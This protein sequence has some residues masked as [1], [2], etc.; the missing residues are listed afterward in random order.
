VS[1]FFNISYNRKQT[2]MM[3]FRIHL[4][5][6]VC[7]IGSIAACTGS[8]TPSSGQVTGTPAEAFDFAEAQKK[9]DPAARYSGDTLDS[10][11]TDVVTFIGRKPAI[12]DW[13]TRFNPE[14]RQH[15]IQMRPE[16]ELVYYRV[17]DDGYHYFYLIRPA[18]SLQGNLRGVGGRFRPGELGALH[19][20]EEVFNT[21]VM[22]EEVL[23]QRGFE[24]FEHMVQHGNVDPF[25]GDGTYIEWPDDRMKYHVERK[26]WRYVDAP[27]QAE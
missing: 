24:L 13:Q 8:D 2:M 11:M 14:H 9:Y 25:V 17:A 4:V 22:S 20:F 1:G 12:S 21:V 16:F 15:Y 23:R 7:T 6:M 27:D 3:T 5:A 10:F 26:E 19:D 18:R